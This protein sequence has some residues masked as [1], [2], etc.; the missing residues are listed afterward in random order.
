MSEGRIFLLNVRL[1][2]ILWRDLVKWLKARRAR[3]REKRFWKN[4][5]PSKD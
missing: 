4:Y 1:V 2:K 3:L 5:D